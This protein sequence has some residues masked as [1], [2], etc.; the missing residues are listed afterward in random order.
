MQASYFQALASAADCH[1][2]GRSEEAVSICQRILS[3]QPDQAE[4]RSLLAT[5]ADD[6]CDRGNVLKR[7]GDS[8]GAAESYRR[9][10]QVDANHARACVGLGMALSDQ[11]R[12]DEAL[13]W[14]ERLPTILPN[15]PLA[16]CALAN[17]LLALT[18]VD[19]AA[20]FYRRALSI[21]PHCADAHNG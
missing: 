21:D 11:G 3:E 14:Y 2:S 5:I 4:A 6:H 10:L 8:A 15:E 12:E 7:T 18:R 13:P 17:C 20:E 19:E 9:A 16:H 1:R